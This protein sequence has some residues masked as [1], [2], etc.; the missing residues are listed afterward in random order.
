MDADGPNG[1]SGHGGDANDSNGEELTAL[2]DLN[3]DCVGS[4]DTPCLAQTAIIKQVWYLYRCCVHK[5]KSGSNVQIE[6]IDRITA[7]IRL[8]V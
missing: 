5:F 2:G 6:R 1:S 7:H 4:E 8:F 3:G